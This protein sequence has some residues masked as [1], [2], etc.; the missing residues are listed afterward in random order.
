MSCREYD[1]YI[2]LYV[3]QEISESDRRR[4]LEHTRTCPACRREL[5]EMVALVSSMEDVQQEIRKEAPFQ[6]NGLFKWVAVCTVA[7]SFAYLVIPFTKQSLFVKDDPIPVQPMQHSVLVLAGQEETL[8]IPQDDSI[9][10][11]HPEQ[12]SEELYKSEAALVYPSA[13]SFF[14]EESRPWSDYTKRF[15]FVRVPDEQTLASLLTYIG[16]KVESLKGLSDIQYPTSIMIS[17][18]ETIEYETFAFPEKERDISNLFERI[19]SEPSV[20]ESQ[21]LH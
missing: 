12:W 2:Q 13:Y 14:L 19:S 3:D 7:V 21:L 1:H 4:L 8:H 6:F 17:L 20:S 10:I 9:R 16:T 18:D 5:K 15:V 11:V